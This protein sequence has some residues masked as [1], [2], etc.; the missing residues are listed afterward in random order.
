MTT[1]RR[2][3]NYPCGLFKH[4]IVQQCIKNQLIRLRTLAKEAFGVTLTPSENCE[5]LALLQFD[6]DEWVT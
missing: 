2:S 1:A 5:L 6:G 3:I 4:T